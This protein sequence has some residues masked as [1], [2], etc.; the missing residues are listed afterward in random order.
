M[1]EAMVDISV[2]PKDSVAWGSADGRFEAAKK[3]R[4]WVEENQ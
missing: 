2:A 4:I 1:A 3:L